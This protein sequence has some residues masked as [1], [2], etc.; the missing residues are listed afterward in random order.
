MRSKEIIKDLD[1]VKSISVIANM[2]GGKLIQKS[3]RKDL[4]SAIDS[5][6]SKYKTVKPNQII[7]L[8][9]T[10]KSTLDMLRVF[11]SA[12]SNKKML[13]EE[14]VKALEEEQTTS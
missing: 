8:C 1:V 7:A 3:L 13:E 14:L 10:I 11:S 4:I 5:L 2:E 12:K 6:S 9:A